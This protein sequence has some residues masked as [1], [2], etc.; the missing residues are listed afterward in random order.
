MKKTAV[1]I[2]LALTLTA[3]G[4]FAM[5]AKPQTLEQ[6]IAA[7]SLSLDGV[8]NTHASLISTG[9]V[10]KALDTELVAQEATADQ[11][12]TLARIAAKGG[13]ITTAQGQLD[14]MKAALIAMNK[15]IAELQAQQPGATK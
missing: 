8:R 3:C 5:T 1:S 10:T 2:L 14:I 9:R 11:A 13:D 7:A 6:N 15:R 12:L 4:M